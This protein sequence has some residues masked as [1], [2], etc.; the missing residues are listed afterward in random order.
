MKYNGLM[1]KLLLLGVSTSVL[2]VFLGTMIPTL[3]PDAFML[4]N[5]LKPCSLLMCPHNFGIELMEGLI[6]G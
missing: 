2:Q 1:L 3:L 5:R 6:L 4:T